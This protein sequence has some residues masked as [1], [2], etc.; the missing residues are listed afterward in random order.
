[1]RKRYKFIKKLRYNKFHNEFL[2]SIPSKI[3]D[4]MDLEEGEQ[5]K[6]ELLNYN[7]ILVTRV[8]GSTEDEKE[9][10]ED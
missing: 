4:R 9:N 8:K 2:L 1:M 10:E 5:V 6:V 7:E 3:R